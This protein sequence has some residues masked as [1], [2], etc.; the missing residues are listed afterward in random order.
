MMGES[1]QDAIQNLQVEFVP[2]CGL[3]WDS[4]RW[5]W[6]LPL[7]EVGSGN[8][9]RIHQDVVFVSR[10]RQK[11][12]GGWTEWSPWTVSPLGSGC[13]DDAIPG[14]LYEAEV[15]ARH[16]S[17]GDSDPKVLS[18]IGPG[19]PLDSTV[20]PASG[21][22]SRWKKL[23][24]DKAD[25]KFGIPGFANLHFTWKREKQESVGKQ[26]RLTQ[27]QYDALVTAGKVDND[28]LYLIV[29]AQEGA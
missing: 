29:E 12:G 19:R 24:L 4:V 11:L 20:P 18:L 14:V 27:A 28:T 17:L 8:L 2:N 10:V 1:Q 22:S 7:R 6:V 15:V 26:E 3:C 25:V 9:L 5:E 21:Q 16:E 23:A 13:I